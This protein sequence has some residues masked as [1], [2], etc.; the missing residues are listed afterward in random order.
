MTAEASFRSIG[1][2][3]RETALSSSRPRHAGPSNGSARFGEGRATDMPAGRR[4][5]GGSFG[6]TPLLLQERLVRC[7]PQDG[8][9]P[10][11]VHDGDPSHRD[12]R[13]VVPEDVGPGV[14]G[15]L[16]G[17]A[18]GGRCR[19]GSGHRSGEHR[20]GEEAS[21][22]GVRADRSVEET[23]GASPGDRATLLGARNVPLH[24]ESVDERD[25][26]V[27]VAEVRDM[28]DSGQGP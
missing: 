10:P 20:G 4:T 8:P 7:A 26:L 3:K 19:T 1:P 13:C 27:G 15:M 12:H 28:A 14:D 16:A 17:R 2:L 9:A 25:E 22:R 11:T 5:R 18:E 23:A 24:E 21:S 6:S